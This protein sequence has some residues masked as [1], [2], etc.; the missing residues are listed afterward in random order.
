MRPN[1]IFLVGAV[2]NS[3]IKPEVIR[4]KRSDQTAIVIFLGNYSLSHLIG[5]SNIS[6]TAPVGSAAIFYYSLKY[7]HTA[8]REIPPISS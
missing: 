2:A 7:E 8:T 5:K 4:A 6:G 3:A 1:T